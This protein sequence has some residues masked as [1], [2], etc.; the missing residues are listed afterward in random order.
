MPDIYV[1][2][3]ENANV[4]DDAEITR[5]LGR[6]HATRP[7]HFDRL[8]SS[9]IARPAGIKF[10]TQELKEEII[11]LMRR[12]FITNIPWIFFVVFLLL[13]PFVIIPVL[14]NVDLLP[15][16]LPITYRVILVLYWYLGI[17]GLFLVNF[18]DWYFNIYILTNRRIIDI[19]FIGLLYKTLSSADLQRIE[20]VTYK[21]TGFFSS[22]FNY[23]D[24]VIQTAGSEPNFEFLAVGKPDELVRTINSLIQQSRGGR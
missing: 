8:F 3:Q 23:G 5:I 18:F 22:F 13:L 15:F 4:S 24:V 10:E 19:D 2:P 20:D 14:V 9:F 16:A 21:Q 1:H 12:A 17:F 11:L 7:S 6:K